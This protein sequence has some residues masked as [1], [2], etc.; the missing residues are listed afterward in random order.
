M[1]TEPISIQ[2]NSSGQAIQIPDEFR[3]NDDKVYLKKTGNVIHIIPYHQPWQNLFDSLEEFTNDFMDNRN[4]PGQQN[5][6]QFD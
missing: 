4:Q 2:T 3:I 1:T 6:E 5:R